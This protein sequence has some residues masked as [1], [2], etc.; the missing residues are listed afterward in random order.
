MSSLYI[1]ASPIGNLEDIT[2]R[3]IKTI[4]SLDLLL[5]EDTRKTKNLLDF[6]AQNYPEISQSNKQPQLLSYFEQNEDKR[7]PE[8]LAILNQGQKVGLVSNAGT[9]TISDPGYNLVKRC[10][11]QNIPVIPIPGPNAAIASLSASGL[12]A[13][14]FLFL[15]FLPRK[16]GKQIKIFEDIKESKIS[17]TVIFY[18]SNFRLKKTLQNIK[19]V[20]GDIEITVS[21]ELTKI[22]EEINSMTISSWE[23]KLSKPLKGE[24]VV[25]FRSEKN[26]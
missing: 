10:R 12:S 13:D 24:I 20:F 15:S 6:L 19:S 1:I 21:R 7:I 23:E 4:F 5:C 18:E 11:Q 8:I 9:P 3:A 26:S 25:L 2:L 22:H 16:Q 17:K 14:K